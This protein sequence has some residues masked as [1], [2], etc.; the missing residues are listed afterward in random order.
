MFNSLPLP[1]RAYHSI[2]ACFGSAWFVYEEV[3]SLTS[4]SFKKTTAKTPII[5]TTSFVMWFNWP[6]IVTT[7]IFSLLEKN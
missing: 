7:G 3:S 5:I 4:S 1:C 6:L 2:G